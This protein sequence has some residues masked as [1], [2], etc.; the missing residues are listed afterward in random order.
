MTGSGS[1]AARVI[2]VALADDHPIVLAGFQQLLAGEPDIQVVATVTRGKDVVDAVRDHH[3]DVLVL[4]LRMPGMDGVEVLR[5]LQ[6]QRV[7]THVVILTAS[8]SDQVLE[9][10]RLGAQGV[11][12]KDMT[13][14]LL[15]RCV[16]AVNAGH[17]WIEKALA[18]RA[19]DHMLMRSSGERDLNALLTAREL[20]VAR[21]VAQGLSNKS[22]AARLNITEG[23]VKLHI[24][25]VYA[26]LGL[27]GRM[28][29]SQFLRSKGIAE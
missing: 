13:L 5:E 22:V 24:H 15:V 25:H 17:K 19:L 28:A 16:R 12:L 27:D 7:E 11:V 8:E 20:E 29:L 21:L 14:E 2:R 3:V 26:K 6:R 4:D 18:T 23:T 10:I 9:A 1:R